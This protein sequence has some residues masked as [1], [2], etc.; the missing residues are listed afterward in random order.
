MNDYTELR[1]N[2]ISDGYCHV[3][4]ITS[5]HLVNEMREKADKIAKVV[6]L[7]NL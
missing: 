4:Q 7:S 5:S 2:L 3:R 6:S 1:K